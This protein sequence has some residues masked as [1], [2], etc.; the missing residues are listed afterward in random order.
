MSKPTKWHVRPAKTQIS[1]GILPVGSEYSLSAWR[2]LGSLA[3]HWAHS[4]DSDQTG[5]LSLTN[6]HRT[7]FSFLNC[8]IWASSRESL[9]SGFRPGKIQIGLLSYTDQLESW[10]FW[11]SKYRY[12]TI[13]VA[14]NKGADQT[15]Q[16]RRLI[17]TFC[18][19]HM[20][21]TGFLMTW[22]ISIIY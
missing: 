4:E 16:M 6:Y 1:L 17:C 13:Q 12:Y 8:Y 10:N 9:S 11:Y 7:S 19:S 20:A 2:R 18:C 14:N 15:A 22:L 21:K 5:R 3:T